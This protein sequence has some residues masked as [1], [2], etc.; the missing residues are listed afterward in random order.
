MGLAFVQPM[1]LLQGIAELSSDP[2]LTVLM[3]RLHYAVIEGEVRGSGSEVRGSGS[4]ESRRES[5][6]TPAYRLPLEDRRRLG[7]VRATAA[8][9]GSGRAWLAV[10]TNETRRHDTSPRTMRLPWLTARGGRQRHRRR[11]GWQ[12]RR[13][14]AH[15]TGSPAKIRSPPAAKEPTSRQSW[16]FP[17]LAFRSFPFIWV[18][19]IQ[20]NG[21]EQHRLL[22]RSCLLPLHATRI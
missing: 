16:A 13:P 19:T 21:M 5:K 1:S 7:T 14:C 22:S 8:A 17:L 2:Q 4:S 9:R 10:G 18:H 20:W 15:S 6:R 12:A 11:H 3:L